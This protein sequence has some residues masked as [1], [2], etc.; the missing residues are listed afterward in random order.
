MGVG[1][2][3]AKVLT[4][5]VSGLDVVVIDLA[6]DLGRPR[7]RVTVE[8]LEDIYFANQL[9]TPASLLNLGYQSVARRRC[10]FLEWSWA[11]RDECATRSG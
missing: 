3:V 1:V 11:R 9:S 5:D 2:G 4:S 10:V 7:L 8:R 6:D